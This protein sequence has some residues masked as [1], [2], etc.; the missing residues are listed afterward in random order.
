MDPVLSAVLSSWNWRIEIVV[1]LVLAGLI[2][3]TGW[4]RLRNR[5]LNRTRS[6]Q[7]K[8]PPRLA[9]EWR[10]IAYLGGLT[11]VGIALMSPID[12]LG[13]QL[14]YMHMIQHLL[15]VMQL[16]VN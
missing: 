6:K 14:F 3:S 11:L 15:L 10:L 16:A 7:S 1:V 8:H 4:Q 9:T 5:H 12:I 2:Y 13:G